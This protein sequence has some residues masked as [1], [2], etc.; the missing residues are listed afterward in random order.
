MVAAPQQQTVPDIERLM[1]QYGDSLLRI[2]FTYLKDYQAAEDAVQETFIR[3]Y[4]HYASF[5]G[6][7]SEKT[8]ITRIAINICKTMLSKRKNRNADTL[9]ALENLPDDHSETFDE[10][11]DFLM[12]AVMDLPQK[13]KDVVLMFYYQDL[14][15]YEI[16]GL[17]G[18]SENGVSTR[19]SRARAMLKQSV[20]RSSEK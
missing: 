8:W 19:L 14:N 15:T 10:D 1:N 7:C 2:V 6:E 5:R 17:L 13:Y 12:T 11:H 18:I 9:D 4:T 16:A 20:E 3:V